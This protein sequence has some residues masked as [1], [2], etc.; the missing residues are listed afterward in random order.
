MDPNTAYL[1]DKKTGFPTFVFTRRRTLPSVETLLKNTSST[2]IND[3]LSFSNSIEDGEHIDIRTQGFSTILSGNG[4]HWPVSGCNKKANHLA[5]PVTLSSSHLIPELLSCLGVPVVN[6][7]P[8]LVKLDVA[9]PPVPLTGLVLLAASPSSATFTPS[10]TAT[11][12]S[13]TTAAT[14]FSLHFF[15]KSEMRLSF[16]SAVIIK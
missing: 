16:Y 12:T 9:Q 15:Y 11:A 4:F 14:A 7:L 1:A 3:M 2:I 10:T 13:T 8:I 6:H 5:L